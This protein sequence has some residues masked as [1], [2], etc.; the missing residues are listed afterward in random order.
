MKGKVVITGGAGFIGSNLGYTLSTL[1]YD[2]LIIDDMSFGYEENLLRDGKTFSEFHKIDVR[3]DGLE[4][5]FKDAICVFHL[6]AISALPVC[7]NNPGLAFDV[8]V[9]G[10]ANVLEAARRSNVPRVVFA[11]TSAI[12]ENNKEF[13]CKEEDPVDP[14]LVYPLTKYCSERVC[15]SFQ[16]TYGMDIVMLRYFNVYGAYQDCHRKL[17]PLIIYII[18]ELLNGRIPVLHSDGT[19]KRDYVHVEDVNDLNILCMEH[20]NAPGEIFNVASG[21]TYSVNE[22]Y[23]IIASQLNCNDSPKFNA[24]G[25]FWDKYP[26]L[27]E[28]K[29]PFDKRILEDEVQKFTLGSGEKAEKLL[30]W[31][32]KKS[33]KAGLSDTID[34]IK[35]RLTKK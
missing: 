26:H 3:S 15:E 30:G 23:E 7:Q 9:A 13:P 20:E 4:R 5:Y 2:V 25:N 11:S 17:P 29:Y 19:Q 1:G 28:G 8:N 27:F 21:K 35:S 6:A 18:N 22:I 32:A 10:T 24:A 14:Q 12:Y 31:A 33:M 16:K 34:V